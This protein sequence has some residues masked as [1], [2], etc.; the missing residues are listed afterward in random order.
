MPRPAIKS[1]RKSYEAVTVF[2]HLPCS[3]RFRPSPSASGR[4]FA[5]GLSIYS[6]FTKSKKMRPRKKY[7]SFE[8]RAGTCRKKRRGKREGRH[9]KSTPWTYSVARPGLQRSSRPTTRDVLQDRTKV[10]SPSL[11]R[12]FSIFLP[13]ASHNPQEAPAGV[14]TYNY[15]SHEPVT[16]HHTSHAPH[17]TPHITPRHSTVHHLKSL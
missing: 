12:V 11:V 8:T 7:K 17:A 2:P 14:L 4:C 9:R 5:L 6:N 16:S 3:W 15:H 10:R 13:Q 1:H